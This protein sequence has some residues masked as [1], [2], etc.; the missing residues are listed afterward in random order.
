MQ[1]QHLTDTTGAAAQPP[2]LDVRHVEKVYGS[3][4][5]VTRALADV[6]FTVQRGEFGRNGKAQTEDVEVEFDKVMSGQ[7]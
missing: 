4:N 5:N 6:S 1:M 2:V 3:R 7:F